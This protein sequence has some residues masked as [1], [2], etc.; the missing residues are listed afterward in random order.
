MSL[1]VI[2]QEKCKHDG[3]C[4]A[5]CP[6][7]IIEMKDKESVPTPTPEAEEICIN[8]GHCVAVCPH[9]AFSLKTMTPEQCQPVKKDLVL[10]REQVEQFLCSRRSVR[11]YKDKPVERETITKL[12]D[13][14]KYAP[15]GRNTQPAEWMVIYDS[16]EVWRMTGLVADWMRY[17]LKEQPDFAN[18]LNLGRVVD[19]WESG[20]D[21][22]CRKAPHVIVVHAAKD[23][24]MAPTASV[25]A[26]SYLELA[27]PGFGLGACWAGYFN[28]AANSWPP[29]QEALGLPK[30]HM[31]LGVL[32]I[33]HPKY[34]FHRTPLRN[35]AKVTWK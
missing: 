7:K 28:T 2:D 23:N 11:V 24:I 32:M 20:I 26:L 17:M 10:N 1:F 19:D 35:D 29:L 18:T 25:I 13:I 21:H 27:V 5:E 34:K 12:I 15:S 16:S 8:C 6:T 9:E 33:G 31:S 4:V 3:I 14:A 30:G 22:I